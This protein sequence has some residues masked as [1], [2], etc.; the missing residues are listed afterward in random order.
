MREIYLSK[1][2]D[3]LKKLF[4]IHLVFLVFM[5]L[6]RVAFFTYYLELDSF[7]NY[8]FDILNAFF[9]GF[10]ID[11]TVVG[12]IQVLPTLAL[13][14][15]Y[16]IKKDSLYWLFISFL[17]YYLFFTYFIVAILLFADFGF[18]SYFK[19]H[20]NL[21]FFGLF[22]DDTSALMVTFWQN[23]NVVGL[24]GSFLAYLVFIFFV[25]R[26]I[27]NSNQKDINSFFGLKIA[28]LIFL[29]LIAFNFFIIRGS[30]GMYPLGKMIANVSENSYIN[31]I[32]QNGVRAFIS[33]YG[34]RKSFISKKLDYIKLLGFENR[35]EDAFKYSI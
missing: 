6:F 11:L 8:Y 19:E 29:I 14:A 5:T 20:I 10:R 31:K 30:I 33:A 9:L 4:Y 26:K 1:T 3:I 24:L 15:L 18:Y 16:Y 27:L 17:K 13:I 22:E 12:Y 35:I 23:Y 32:P 2:F 21:L 28:P 25:I 7:D 34:V